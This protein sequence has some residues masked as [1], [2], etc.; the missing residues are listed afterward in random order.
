MPLFDY[1]CISCGHVEEN[2]LVFESIVVGDY[3]VSSCPIC[4]HSMKRLIGSAHTHFRGKGFYE[5]DYKG[6]K[7]E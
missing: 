2:V 3:P 4:N 7:R 1:K 5:T 6:G